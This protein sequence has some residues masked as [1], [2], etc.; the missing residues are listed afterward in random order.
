MGLQ[1]LLGGG[2]K[3]KS[4]DLFLTEK[5]KNRATGAAIAFFLFSSFHPP[6]SMFLS[7]PSVIFELAGRKKPDF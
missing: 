6:R 5:K 1:L 7:I 4:F 3:I 2:S